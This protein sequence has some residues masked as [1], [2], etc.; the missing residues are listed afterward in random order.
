MVQFISIISTPRSLTVSV[1]LFFLDNARIASHTMWSGEMIA[2]A[3]CIGC[4]YGQSSKARMSYVFIILNF[5][6]HSDDDTDKTGNRC[7]VA[8]CPLV[9][10]VW[11]YFL[12]MWVKPPRS[13]I[14]TFNSHKSGACHNKRYEEPLMD[15]TIEDTSL[16]SAYTSVQIIMVSGRNKR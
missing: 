3:C 2:F 6:L 14:P 5:V 7:S 11:N 9:F 8:V 16:C 13:H 12:I 15:L 1:L 10:D 4:K